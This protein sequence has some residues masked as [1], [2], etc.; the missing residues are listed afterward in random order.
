M[1]RYRLPGWSFA[2]SLSLA[3]GCERATPAKAGDSAIT[4]SAAPSEVVTPVRDRSGWDDAAGPAL[5]VASGAADEAIV[6]LPFSGDTASEERLLGDGDREA[7]VTMLGRGG[8]RF[9]ARLDSSP[10]EATADCRRWPLQDVQPDRGPGS[11]SVGFVDAHVQPVPLDSVGVLTSRDSVALV[12]EAARLASAV[13][14]RTGASFQGLRFTAQDLHRFQAAPAVQALVALMVRRVNQEANPQEERTL[15]I[16]ER[17]SGTVTGPYH[18][19]YA[20]RAFGREEGVPT[21]EVLAGVR[22]AA[23]RQPALVVAREGDAGV[24]YSFIERM[25]NRRWRLRWTSGI[26]RCN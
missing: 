24:V 23:N 16:A 12:S 15:L 13:T 14:A 20:E 8:E 3:A 19:V 26:T 1:P 6:L 5:L 7:P 10:E 9:S 21:P 17:D 25:D 4:T 18:L 2:L 11:W 22:M